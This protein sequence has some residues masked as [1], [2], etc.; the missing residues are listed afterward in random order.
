MSVSAVCEWGECCTTRVDTGGVRERRETHGRGRTDADWAALCS[1]VT[2]QWD[3]HD[4]N[5]T[6]VAPG[7]AQRSDHPPFTAGWLHATNK[8]RRSVQAESARHDSQRP[9]CTRQLRKKKKNCWRRTKRE[10][11]GMETAT[12]TTSE[13]KTIPAAPAP[14]G[15]DES[16]KRSR[17]Q[18]PRKCSCCWRWVPQVQLQP[19]RPRKQPRQGWLR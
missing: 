12:M 14:R 7:T 3:E 18:L 8:R 1:G 11:M 19:R 6:T 9:T 2:S 17:S 5:A 13:H 15:R 16:L 4:R 10:A